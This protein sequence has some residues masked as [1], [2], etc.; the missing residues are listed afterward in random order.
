LQ[1]VPIRGE[2]VLDAPHALFGAVVGGAVEVELAEQGEDLQGEVV[3]G[4][5][6]KR[7]AAA[8]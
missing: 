1:Q 3:K 5:F 7:P 8:T 2:A 4:A 6:Y